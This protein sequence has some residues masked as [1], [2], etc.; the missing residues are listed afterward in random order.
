MSPLHGEFT[1]GF[2]VRVGAFVKCHDDVGAEVLLNRNGLFGCEAMRRAVNV[3]LESHTIV[4]DLASLRQREDLKAA[5]VGEHGIRPLHE[6]V[7]A[8][9]VADEFVAGA[10][11]EMI[12]VAQ[13]ERGVDL[14]EMFGRE[15]FDRC[16][17]AH[18]R[19]DWREK[20]AVWRGENPG[21]GAV[22]FGRDLELEHWS[23][24]TIFGKHSMDYQTEK[25]QICNVIIS[26]YFRV[27]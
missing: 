3:T 17:R 11:V 6:L 7:Q 1:I 19:E 23:D 22:V 20:V 14:L 13:D 8:T 9:H 18:R 25:I 21:A 2:V 5:R 12:S 15:G 26:L 10:Q 16:L 4:V 27:K 24:Y